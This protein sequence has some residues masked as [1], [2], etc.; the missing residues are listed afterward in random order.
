MSSRNELHG[1]DAHESSKYGYEAHDECLSCKQD[2][3]DHDA[4][5]GSGTYECIRNDDAVPDV[6][7]DDAHE[8]HECIRNEHIHDGHGA[9]GH[10]NE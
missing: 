9:N 8:C 3:H 2:M 1:D 10:G 4:H 6:H 7:E 5:D